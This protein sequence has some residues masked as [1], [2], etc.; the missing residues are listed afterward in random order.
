V[1]ALG[2]GHGLPR[3][4]QAVS[5]HLHHR[6]LVVDSKYLVAELR[7]Q[8]LDQVID[9][10]KIV[11]THAQLELTIARAQRHHDVGRNDMS[12]LLTRDRGLVLGPVRHQ[13]SA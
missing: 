3:R 6:A 2:R 8:L 7:Q 1:P 10:G 4:L 9:P 5:H 13:R 11:A 12:C